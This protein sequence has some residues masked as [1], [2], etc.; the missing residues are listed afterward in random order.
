MF[1]R[2]WK[3]L[4]EWLD[5]ASR[6]QTLL[7][8]VVA[9]GGGS[10]MTSI[11]Q[12]LSPVSGSWLLIEGIGWFS[13]FLGVFARKLESDDRARRQLALATVEPLKLLPTSWDSTEPDIQF[14]E[15]HITSAYLCGSS[16]NGHYIRVAPEGSKPVPVTLATCKLRGK[17]KYTSALVSYADK[18]GTHA[19][20][21]GS[22][23]N[24]S[25][26]NRVN[27]HAG[28]P[29]ELILAMQCP[30]LSLFA[31]DDKRNN[32]GSIGL[33]MEQ[34]SFPDESAISASVQLVSGEEDGPRF[35]F[36]ITQAK[37]IFRVEMKHA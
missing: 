17:G 7:A 11:A 18:T 13:V 16:I 19:C 22:W 29:E 21:Q 6:V 5:S 15:C 24:G 25:D 32:T 30:D 14:L 9:F 26:L 34:L 3:H 36:G 2:L 35:E 37:G 12:I 1:S 33:R 28:M 8:I 23:L 10:L 20:L 31:L 27:L 4:Q